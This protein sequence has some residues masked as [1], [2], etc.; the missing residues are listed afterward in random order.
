MNKFTTRVSSIFSFASSAFMVMILVLAILTRNY[1]DVPDVKLSVQDVSLSKSGIP[2]YYDSSSKNAQHAR[3]KFSISADM[4]HLFNWNTKQLFCYLL[5]EYE[6]SDDTRKKTFDNKV[7]LWDRIITSPKKAKINL[8]K[9]FNK[10][11]FRDYNLN[12]INARDAKLTLVI[13]R[14]P[15]LG[16]FTNKS[17]RS[18]DISFPSE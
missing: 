8:K 10:Y 18:V 6:N 13:E 3:V 17:E 9:H 14:V 4:T 11:S 7:I 1:Q 5:I 12:F 15:V 2:D 16:F